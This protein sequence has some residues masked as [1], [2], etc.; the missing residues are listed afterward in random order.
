MKRSDLPNL[1]ALATIQVANGLMPLFVFPYTLGVVGAGPYS[2]L[3][4]TEAIMFAVLALVL[5]SFEVDGVARV[6]SLDWRREHEVL[7]EVFNAV[8]STRLLILS[9]C[10]GLSLLAQIFVDPLTGKMILLWL[11][12]PLSYVLQSTWLFQA[13]EKNIVVAVL[14][15]ASRLSSVMFII[16][17]VS[18]PSDVLIVPAI[19]GL[20]N[21]FA[22]IATLI[23]A[24]LVLGIN[25]RWTTKIELL[26]HLHHGWPVF[27]G[28]MAVILYRD[29]NVVILS[30]MQNNATMIAAYSIAEKLI[31]ALQATMRPLNQIFFPKTLRE[32]G[33]NRCADVSSFRTIL[34]YT[35]PQW[36]ALTAVI[37][38]A[39]V[40]YYL[41]RDKFEV[42]SSVSEHW[43]TVL[44]LFTML[45]TPYFGIANFMFGTAGLNQL[46]GRTYLYRAIVATGLVSIIV[47]ALL[48][49]HFGALGAA[50]SFV[51]AELLLFIA[52][53]CAYKLH[54]LFVK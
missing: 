33:S 8:L 3:A 28:N 48:S 15:V 4:L 44:L 43:Q 13:I 49:Y 23:Y 19:I 30:A 39:C 31:K 54:F 40:I 18:E 2:Q 10:V 35:Y 9:V 41:G 11:M 21:L 5:Y 24:H 47:C 32:L 42:L 6:V 50:L 45:L 16:V 25:L 51:F 22:A 46:G 26:K 38:L 1:A 27:V 20:C 12:V 52:I 29:F 17:F 34:S 14:T 53:I 36:L 37:S 7:S